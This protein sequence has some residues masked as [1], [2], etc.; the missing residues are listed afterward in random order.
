MVTRTRLL[1]ITFVLLSACRPAPR[2]NPTTGP[3]AAMQ[4]TGPS[5]EEIADRIDPGPQTPI[6]QGL[7]PWMFEVLGLS[8]SPE[9]SGTKLLERSAAEQAEFDGRLETQASD[10]VGMVMA[11]RALAR[12]VVL[13]EQAAAKGAADADTLA[14]LER[15]YEVVD[16]PMV[17]SDQSSFSQLIVVFAQTAQAEGDL[18]ETAEL[19]ELARVVQRATEA[20]GPLHRRTVAELL[21]MDPDHDAVPTAILEVADSLRGEDDQWSVELAT[22]AV[23]RRGEGASGEEQLKLAGICFAAL[24]L[25]CGDAA[26]EAAAR[27]TSV[28][29]ADIEHATADGELARTIISLAGAKT[30]A[31]RV[32]CAGA[33][34]QLGRFDDA[35]ASFEVLR[36]EHPQD[37]R[38]VAGLAKHAIDTKLDFLGA[39]AIIDGA[40]PVENADAQ[41]YQLAIGTR[42]MATIATIVPRLAADDP[43]GAIAA[44]RPSMARMHEDVDGYA[45]LGNS[46]G[47]F[48]S[49][50]LEI[51]EEVLAQYASMGVVRVRDVKSLSQ[52]T[53]A[54]QAKVPDNPH[55]YRLLQSVSLFEADKAIA[56]KATQVL[57]AAGTEHDALA[58]RRARALADLAVTWADPLLA[59]QALAAAVSLGPT[60]TRMRADALLIATALGVRDNWTEVGEGFETML[61]DNMTSA[62]ARALNNVAMALWHLGNE[63]TA[64]E[65][66]SLSAQLGEDHADVAKLNLVVSDA[67]ATGAS[68]ELEALAK[69]GRVAGV[70]VVARAWLLARAKRKDAKRR[71]AELEAAITKEREDT[72]RPN[73][74]DPYVGVL[75]EGTLSAGLGYATKAGL[76][77]DLDSSGVAWAI[78]VPK[79]P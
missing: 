6:S 75:L 64:R 79:R 40:G 26:L 11:L 58:T 72:V 65:A 67:G 19:G 34:L 49:F 73:A 63:D 46:D 2:E 74:P 25:D 51:A 55:A 20:A 8:P 31:E 24:Q 21:R 47:V 22:L 71:A 35:K 9:E 36:E 14:R 53:L 70:R 52:R 30:L 77:I 44:L 42:A 61:D 50:V 59:E 4:P 41:Y 37:A 1:G 66:W 48:L 38:P 39:H 18:P 7:P 78:R 57:P 16:A 62:D 54:L 76:Q 60:A 23:E 12:S 5:L 13:A 43:S 68:A 29:P 32:E 27:K 28:K 45:A 33:Q 15:V 10:N 56:A 17:A 69:D 3:A